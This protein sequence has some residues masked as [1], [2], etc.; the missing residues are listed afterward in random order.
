LKE[1][2]KPFVPTVRYFT[3]G[4]MQITTEPF[5]NSG[6]CVFQMLAAANVTPKLT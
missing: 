4:K 6:S 5:E 2:A 1:N 3:T